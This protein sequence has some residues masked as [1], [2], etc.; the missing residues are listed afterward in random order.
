MLQLFVHRFLRDCR[1]LIIE[2][3]LILN[4]GYFNRKDTYNRKPTKKSLNHY[5][6]SHQELMSEL[7]LVQMTIPPAMM[8][9]LLDHQVEPDYDKEKTNF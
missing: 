1:V 3:F 9:H 8:D 5:F 2:T 7:V 4:K 6:F